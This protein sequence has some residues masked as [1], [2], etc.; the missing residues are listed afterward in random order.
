MPMPSRWRDIRS[1][2]IHNSRSGPR[3]QHSRRR[4]ANAEPR[5]D[6]DFRRELGDRARRVGD[7]H[8]SAET[9]MSLSHSD[10]TCEWIDLTPHSNAHERVNN[11]ETASK[12]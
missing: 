3:A 6:S 9:V 5:P 11:R 2:D 8:A 12:R 7:E 1:H 4:S 10:L